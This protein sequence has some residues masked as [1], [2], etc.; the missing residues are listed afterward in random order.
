MDPATVTG[1]CI[2]IAVVGVVFWL[3]VFLFFPLIKSIADRIGGKSAQVA[4]IKQLKKK[5][6]LLE[7]DLDE[8]KGRQMLLE[9]SHWFEQ[10]LMKI[11]KK[12]R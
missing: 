11:P 1:I 2:I 4:E 9:D 12:D 3:P 6:E 8:I 7:R 10:Q 5:V